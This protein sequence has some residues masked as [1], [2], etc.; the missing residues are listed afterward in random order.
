MGSVFCIS[1]KIFCHLCVIA[2][3]DVFEK[4][5]AFERLE[6]KNDTG[7]TKHHK[8]KKTLKRKSALQINHFMS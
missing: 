5:A 8:E 2:E 6:S 1:V 4:K 3:S 7:N